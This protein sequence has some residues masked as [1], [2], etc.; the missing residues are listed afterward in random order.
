MCIRENMIVYHK[1]D[2]TKGVIKSVKDSKIIITLDSPIDDGKSHLVMPLESFGEFLFF[3]EEDVN[4]NCSDL[5]YDNRYFQY[6]TEKI[7]ACMS[8][9]QE[10]N[11]EK[12]NMIKHSV[13]SHGSTDYFHHTEFSNP[14]KH[15]KTKK[16]SSIYTIKEKDDGT[17]ISSKEELPVFKEVQSI[18]DTFKKKLKNLKENDNL[19]EKHFSEAVSNIEKFDE[20]FFYDNNKHAIKINTAYDDLVGSN[21]YSLKDKENFQVIEFLEHHYHA[22]QFKKAIEAYKLSKDVKAYSHSF[23]GFSYDK[24]I[25]DLNN[26]FRLKINS[27]FGYGKSSFLSC[28]IIFKGVP[29]IPYSRLVLY[30]VNEAFSN[31]D[32]T[33]TFDVEEPSWKRMFDVCVDFVNNYYNTTDGKR[34][35]IKMV[36]K[37]INSFAELLQ[38]VSLNSIFLNPKDKQ[39][40]EEYLL[41]KNRQIVYK[42]QEYSYFSDESINNLINTLRKLINDLNNNFNHALEKIKKEAEVVND[43]IFAYAILKAFNTEQ[44]VLNENNHFNSVVKEVFKDKDIEYFI[45]HDFDLQNYRSQ[46]IISAA[47]L[48]K[49]I[50]VLVEEFNVS[51]RLNDI[52]IAKNNVLAQNIKL[53]EKYETKLKD[54]IDSDCNKTNKNSDSI[55]RKINKLTDL[56]S[57][58]NS[59]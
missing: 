6:G 31:I 53:I 33:F 37:S 45:P 19:R 43:Y 48:Y 46:K 57:K 11:T 13:E 36:E 1:I 56:N 23:K 32:Y 39:K 12:E 17:L 24:F 51:N 14:N 47:K 5:M 21:K 58:I 16:Q 55:K 20:L 30:E 18:I 44:Q 49:N 42:N 4:K 15:I 29:L 38:N 28:T 22:Y 50:E 27:N 8:S 35:V 3:R 41:D 25:F 54:L 40:L 10:K 34:K 52:I 7:K 2:R 26:D 59:L 9:I